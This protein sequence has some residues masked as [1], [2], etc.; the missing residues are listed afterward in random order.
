MGTPICTHYAYR[1]YSGSDA[2]AMPPIRIQCLYTDPT[3]LLE[4][5]ST[6]FSFAIAQLL[7]L[8][9]VR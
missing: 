8:R 3:S 9:E 2:F 4:K 5:D 1:D 6:L 7:R